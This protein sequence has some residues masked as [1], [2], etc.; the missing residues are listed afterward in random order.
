MFG[1]VGSGVVLK[2]NWV[3]VVMLV[4]ELVD[5]MVEVRILVVNLLVILLVIVV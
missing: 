2:L 5:V 3:D 1:F 4:S